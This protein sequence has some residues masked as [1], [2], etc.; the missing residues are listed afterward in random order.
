MLQSQN[1][2]IKRVLADN[3]ADSQS[4]AHQALLDLVKFDESVQGANILNEKGDVIASS[5]SV[6]KGNFADREYF[7]K[8]MAGE[9]NVSEPLMSRVTNKPVCIVAAPVKSGDKIVGII[10]ARLDLGKFSESIVAPVKVGKSGY[11][12][13]ASKSGVVFSHP[14]QSKLLKLKLADLEWA[15]PLLTDQSGVVQYRE[16]GI[17]K[18]A[19]FSRDPSTGWIAIITVS[20]VDIANAASRVRTASALFGVL[21]IVLVCLAIM[22]ILNYVLRDLNSCVLFSES[23]A[24][25]N[26]DNN[27][28]LTRDDELGRLADS[29]RKMVGSLRDMI[30]TARQKTAEAEQQTELARKATS[31]AEEAKAEAERA[32]RAGMLH[33]AQQLNSIVEVVTSASTELSAQIEQSS[34]GAEHQAARVSETATAME[35]MTATVIEVAK[36]AGQAAETAGAAR[37]KAQTG[38]GT[39]GKVVDGM[40]G[41]QTQTNQLK[42]DMALLGKQAEDIGRIMTVI[43]DIADQT[44]LLA[45]NAAIEA[46]RAGDAGRG[47]AVVADEVRKLAEKT[48]S[49]TKEVG[50]AISVIQQSTRL[51]VESVDKSVRLIEA[52]TVLAKDSGTALGEIVSLV[53]TASDQVRSIATASEEQS[54]ASEEISRSIEQ[55]NVISTE[56]SQAMN[57]A[58]KAVSDLAEQ[59]QVLQA[60]ITKLD[61][62]GRG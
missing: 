4:S 10:Y 7:K 51:N 40:N 38:A 25:G 36:N 26:I 6:P 27:L 21:G 58:A 30:G 35:E 50:D 44:N 19:I 15:K 11:A 62:E 18:S 56:T 13:M 37:E 9:S 24:A 55:V 53:D 23:V 17:D 46:A 49:A 1:E 59:A 39:V 41:V 61:E 20:S 45:L 48:M 31:E 14:D 3:S 8:A 28:A 5:E 43:T 57:E 16:D 29:L 47:F 54:A 34:R 2:K 12:Y 32:K 42:S 33:A 60:L 22:L 52:A